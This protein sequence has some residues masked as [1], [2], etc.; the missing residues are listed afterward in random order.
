MERQQQLW[1]AGTVRIYS[2][3]QAKQRERDRQKV[4]SG[5]EK[6]RLE[7]RRAKKVGLPVERYREMRALVSVFAALGRADRIA[8]LFIKECEECHTE[9]ETRISHQKLCGSDDC[10]KRWR[11]RKTSAYIVARYRGDSDFRDTVIA[12]SHARRASKLGLGGA[13]ITIGY[14]LERDGWMCGIC[15]RKIKRREDASLD[16]IIPVSRGGPHELANVQ[17][18]HKKCNYAKGNRGGGEQTRLIG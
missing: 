12:N 15:H 10:R 2:D 9:F 5:Q 16:H 13:R 3:R 7:R 11:S 18:S 14:L 1:N 8:P 17:A 6:A 4:A